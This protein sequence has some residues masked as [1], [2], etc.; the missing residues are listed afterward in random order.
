MP[1][2]H[3][4]EDDEAVSYALGYQ[5]SGVAAGLHAGRL[6]A[7]RL[8]GKRLPALGPAF[9]PLQRFPFAAFRRTAQ[10]AAFTWYRI[11]DERA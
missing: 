11:K 6:A 2:I 5:G 9:S 4:A 10:R 7:D 3:H 8:A 1:H